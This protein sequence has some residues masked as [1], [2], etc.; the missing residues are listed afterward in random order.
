MAGRLC[1]WWLGYA[2]VSPMRRF[3]QDPATIL[4]PFVSEGMLV[5]EPGCGMGFFTL[6][7]ARRVGPAG[8][9]VAVDIQE[10]ML[11]GL[12]R[13]ARKA[14]IAERVDARL[15]GPGVYRTDD[16]SGKVDFV[17]AFAVVHE[18]PDPEHFYAEMFRVLRPG[19]KML[20]AEPRAHVKPAQFEESIKAASRVGFRISDRPVIK[21]SRS[22][23]LQ[24]E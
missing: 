2:L 9:V 12:R 11:R 7:L 5:L 18:L 8:K 16:L 22:A 23:V 19:A 17:L 14:G 4:E 15:A 6:E 20:L 3:R 10:K 1:P 13:R 24:R 21:A